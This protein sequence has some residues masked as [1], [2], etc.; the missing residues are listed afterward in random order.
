MVYEMNEKKKFIGISPAGI[1]SGFETSFFNAVEKQGWES[2]YFP[3]ELPCFK[4]LCTLKSFSIN[5][6]KWGLSRDLAYNTSIDAFKKKSKYVKKII[7]KNQ[8]K[9][10]L[11]YQIGGLW[12]PIPNDCSIPHV[13]TIDY[14]SKL[15][16]R[17]KSEWMRKPGDESNFWYKEEKKLFNSTDFI[18]ATTKNAK[19]SLINDYSIP[20]EKIKVVGPGLSEPFDD[21]NDFKLP[22]YQGEK[23]LFIGKGYKG[24]GLDTLIRAFRQIRN[25]LP[26]S[27]LLIVGPTKKIEGDGIEYFGRIADKRKIIDL[28]YSASVFVMPSIFEPVGQVFLEAMSCKL[29]CIGTSVD[30]MPELIKN[31]E[32]GFIVS[33]G[34]IDALAHKIITILTNP[35]LAKN[36]GAKGYKRLKE[37]FTW[38]VVGKKIS[39]TFESLL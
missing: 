28:Y 7:Q 26:K 27:R 2:I 17:R 9:Y 3:I 24:K 19:N 5:K 22:D 35:D 29:P 39:E 34:D 15:S 25:E 18:C 20:S 8:K 31:N 13:L 38:D 11:I 30:A 36:M 10:D 32:T 6:S 23:I 12:N 21:F 16:E 4:L 1:F 33:P 37:K 14:T